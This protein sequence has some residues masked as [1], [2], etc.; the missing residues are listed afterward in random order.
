MVQ[1]ELCSH[2]WYYVLSTIWR[3]LHRYIDIDRSWGPEELLK[4]GGE[5]SENFVFK[6]GLPFEGW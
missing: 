3:S 2:L 1:F 5:G 6:G 4:L